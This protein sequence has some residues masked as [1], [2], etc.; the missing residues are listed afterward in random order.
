MAD[1]T[2]EWKTE[3]TRVG[4]SVPLEL[5]STSGKWKLPTV[6]KK[7][8]FDYFLKGSGFKN[9]KPDA[10]SSEDTFKSVVDTANQT[11]RLK[12]NPRTF[13]YANATLTEESGNSTSKTYPEVT[14][15]IA[16]TPLVKTGVAEPVRL[17]LV[18]YF[19]L[20]KEM[21]KVPSIVV[22]HIG[23]VIGATAPAGFTYSI[24]KLT[25]DVSDTEEAV[26]KDGDTLVFTAGSYELD[27]TV[28][29]T[30][31]NALLD[32]ITPFGATVAIS[33]TDIIAD[34]LTLMKAGEIVIK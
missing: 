2:L 12:L 6:V 26:A 21:Q 19:N 18:Q 1:K 3:G 11:V 4:L 32:D 28:D 23:K 13:T 8:H 20:Q 7:Y 29:L 24:G 30:A 27:D 17:T 16:N 31:V 9:P 5:D 33:P 25:S 22:H 15:V 34:D 14:F 10:S